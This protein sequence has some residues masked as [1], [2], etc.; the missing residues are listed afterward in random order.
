[1]EFKL[2]VLVGHENITGMQFATTVPTK[3]SIGRFAV[4]KA[5]DFMSELGDATGRVLVKTDQEPAIRT[6]VKDLVA[7]R[8]EGRTIVEESP[9]QSSGS[10][11][12][13]ERAVQAIEGHTRILLLSLEARIGR[14]I[15]AK[16]PVVTYMP[17]YAA[18]LLN[19]LHVGKD[20]KRPMSAPR[21]KG[22]S[23]RARV[24]REIPLQT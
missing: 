19:R 24:R 6:F 23:A 8:E 2:V 10:N 3:G 16:E 18:Y 20:G 5:V 17:E 11:G 4:D 9:V 7:A 1:M 15:D 14:A 13:A 21:G 12:R 22:H